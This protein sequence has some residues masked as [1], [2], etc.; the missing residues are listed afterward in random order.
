MIDKIT[1][2]HLTFLFFIPFQITAETISRSKAI[3]FIEGIVK[4]NMPSSY[5]YL[6][7]RLMK[8]LKYDDFYFFNSERKKFL[9][10]YKNI[11]VEIQEKSVN[12]TNF[13]TKD[14]INLNYYTFK[15]T[16][17]KG[18]VAIDELIIDT[19]GNIISYE[20]NLYK[21]TEY[22]NSIYFNE[23]MIDEEEEKQ[24]FYLKKEMLD[25]SKSLKNKGFQKS[26]QLLFFIPKKKNTRLNTINLF[27]VK[28]DLK[29]FEEKSNEFLY[30]QSKKYKV[31][32]IK[33][34]KLSFICNNTSVVFYVSLK[35][36]SK[37]P[38]IKII[39]GIKSLDNNIK[40][41]WTNYNYDILNSPDF[42]DMLI[43]GC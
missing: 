23:I 9:D 26:N 41:Y 5:L 15:T 33:L 14:E 40:Y 43:N 30:L 42:S 8:K 12:K 10:N 17:S 3:S 29:I 25:F 36:N 2:L 31:E 27:Q 13:L 7:N 6:D 18:K 22:P 35:L 24:I 11:N 21:N 19:R 28:K 39:R 1:L 37:F 32:Y 20:L 4:M 34:E 38:I 16:S